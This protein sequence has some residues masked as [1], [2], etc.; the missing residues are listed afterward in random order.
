[1]SDGAAIDDAHDADHAFGH[2][3]YR[4]PS[5]VAYGVSRP[6]FNPQSADGPA[7]TPLERK[8]SRHAEQSLL[9]DNHVLPPKHSVRRQTLFGRL[10]KRLFSTKL[11]S[12]DTEGPH[13]TIQPPSETSPLLRDGNGSAT[14]SDDD[15]LEDQWEQAVAS[16][17]LRTTWQREAKTIATYSVPLIVTFVLQY[18]INVASIFTVGRIGK[19]ELGAVSC[20]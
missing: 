5:G 4:R 17:Q 16:G 12:R 6:V 20:K 13:I 14:P 19:M 10:Y 18:S 7:M 2:T 3:M 15:D 9:R 11:P 1:M 8:Q